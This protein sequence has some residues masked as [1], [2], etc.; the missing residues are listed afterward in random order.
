M[1]KS[2]CAD[3]EK[4]SVIIVNFNSG[5]RL[6]NAIDSL[7]AQT[8]PPAEVIVIDNASEDG[9]TD[10]LDLSGLPGARLCLERTNHGFS[11][12]NNLAARMADGNWL[13]L[14]NPDATAAPDWIEKLL[15]ASRQFP[16]VDMFASAQICAENPD[17]LDGAGDAYSILGIPWRGGFGRSRGELPEAGECFSACGA[18]TFIRRET[19][20][21]LGGFD[22][23]FFCYC[24]DVD[25]GFRLRLQGGRCR[26]VPEALVRHEGSAITGRHSDFTI[27]QGTRNR[28]W[29]YLKNMPPLALALTL[30]GHI[31]ATAYLYVRARGKPYRSAMK[32]GIVSALKG[33]GPIW[34]SRKEVSQ[35]RSLGSLSIMRA[36]DFNLPRLSRRGVHVWPSDAGRAQNV[37][38][39]ERCEDDAHVSG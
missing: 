34:R 1:E 22:E 17:T 5:H 25:L 11:G 29:T 38:D 16:N 19:F 10:G 12:G 14:L 27:R 7:K 18:S 2:R 21:D 23:R 13:A 32:E 3:A 35:R 36:M 39:R 37:G 20:E 6:Q 28:I 33:I 24:E 26:F 9:S 30:P 4:V 8:C 15:A 31:A